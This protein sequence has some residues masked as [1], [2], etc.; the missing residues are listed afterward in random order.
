MQEPTRDGPRHDAM[1]FHSEVVV[2]DLDDPVQTAWPEHVQRALAAGFAS[3]VAVP[4]ISRGRVWGS[5][6]PARS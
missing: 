4:P 1:L 6:D 3:V 5:L 2:D